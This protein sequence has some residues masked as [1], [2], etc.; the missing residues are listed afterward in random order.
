MDEKSFMLWRSLCYIGEVLE[1]V[2]TTKILREE[3]NAM[4]S[5]YKVKEVWIIWIKLKKIKNNR[6]IN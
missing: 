1:Y 5:T 2:Y 4:I 6:Y 3:C